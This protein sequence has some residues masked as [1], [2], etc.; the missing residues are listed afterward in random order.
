MT[1]VDGAA[2]WTL[3]ATH[4][5]PVDLSIPMLASEDCV[6]TWVPLLEAARRDG[7]DMER[8]VTRLCEA[9]SDGY[10]P[11]IAAVIVRKL[12]AWQN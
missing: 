7:A 3:H 6:P 8:L 11:D 12:R 1:L 9:V 2:I 4:G 5:F 10:P